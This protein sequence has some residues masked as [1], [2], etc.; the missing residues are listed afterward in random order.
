MKRK[1]VDT[2]IFLRYLTKDDLGKYAQCLELFKLVLAGKTELI[3][4]N[5][6]IAELIWTLLS[7]YKTPKPVVVEKISILVGTDHLFIPDKEIIIEALILYGKKNIDYIDA[8]NAVFMRHH[9]TNEIFSYDEDFDTLEGVTLQ[10]GSLKTVIRVRKGR[11][12]CPGK[13]EDR[14]K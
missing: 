4:S 9:Q 14:Q 10:G 3:T 5:M 11:C 2:N 12:P 8:Y 13:A 6:V 1:F 7:F